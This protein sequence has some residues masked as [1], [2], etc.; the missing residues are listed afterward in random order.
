MPILSYLLRVRRGLYLRQLR[1][2]LNLTDEQLSRI[3]D[4]LYQEALAILDLRLPSTDWRTPTAKPTAYIGQ[5]KEIALASQKELETILTAEQYALFWDW[6]DC[7][8]EVEYQRLQPRQPAAFPTST[9]IPLPGEPR[10][11]GAGAIPTPSVRRALPLLPVIPTTEDEAIKQ[12]LWL[13][14][15]YCSIESPHDMRAQPMTYEDF[16][17]LSGEKPSEPDPDLDTPVWVVTIKGRF[18]CP[19][20]IMLITRPGTPTHGPLIYE[21]A[22]I[23]INTITGWSIRSQIGEELSLPTGPCWTR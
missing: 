14:H 19:P 5:R 23:V 2:E 8:W 22:Y 20:R 3:R 4:L 10:P 18:V 15:P 7:K 11:T 6:L 17:W 12:A 13:W 9:A 1:A 21:S 16:L